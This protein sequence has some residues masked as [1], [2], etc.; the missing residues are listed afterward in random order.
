MHNYKLHYLQPC[1]KYTVTNRISKLFSTIDLS[2]YA[3]KTEIIGNYADLTN[4][5]N[6]F[7]GNYNSLTNKPTIPTDISQ[8]TDNNNLLSSGG[9][10]GGS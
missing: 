9:G 4:K 7:D 10:G 3:L 1:N 8:L 2:P 6:L 5:P